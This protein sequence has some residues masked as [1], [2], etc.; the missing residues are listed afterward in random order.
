MADAHRWCAGRARCRPRWRGRPE[1]RQR[2]RPETRSSGQSGAGRSGGQEQRVLLIVFRAAQPGGR[3][4][5][6]QRPATARRA[7][8]R[9]SDRVNQIFVLPEH[10]APACTSQRL[11]ECLCRTSLRC[12]CDDHGGQRF[13]WSCRPI[14]EAAGLEPIPSAGW[15]AALIGLDSWEVVYVNDGSTDTTLAVI[16][17]L[18]C[19]RRPRRGGQPVA[20]FRQGDGDHRRS[21]PRRR[22]CRGG[23]RRRPAGPAGADSGA[24]R[25]LARWLRHGLRQAAQPGGRILAEARHRQAV[26]T[27]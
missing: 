5:H 23:H 21:G 19:C 26:S 16:E 4:Q 17:T 11:T 7:R 8:E 24:A 6:Q 25:P 2:R 10:L 1:R 22:R 9:I 18:H 27:G 20:Q 15:C 3:G 13:R 14:N 12:R